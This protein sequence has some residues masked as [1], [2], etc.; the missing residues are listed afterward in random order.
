MDGWMWAQIIW[1][2]TPA[3]FLLAAFLL[4]SFEAMRFWCAVMVTCAFVVFAAQNTTEVVGTLILLVAM[5][6][7]WKHFAESGTPTTPA[8]AKEE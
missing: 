1:S 8:P 5:Y 3:L 7:A 6:F 2:G 4:L